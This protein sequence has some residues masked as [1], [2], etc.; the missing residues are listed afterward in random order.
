N[1]RLVLLGDTAQ[2]PPVETSLSPALDKGELAGYASEVWET[3]LTD[4]LRQEENSGILANA[5]KL[6]EML[7]Q[8]E[9]LSGFPIIDIDDYT[10]IRRISGG[11][12]IE[13]INYCYDNYG[14]EETLIITRSNKR[15]NLYNQGIRN[16]VLHKEEELAPGDFLLIVK[17]NYHWIKEHEEISFIAN[18]DIARVIRIKKYHELYGLR[19]ADITCE[20]T[21]YRNVEID[22][23]VILDTIHSEGPCLIHEHQEIVYSAVMEDY[24]DNSVKRKRYEA[25]RSDE[26]YNSLQIKFAYAMT[27]HKAQ[28]SQWKAVFVDLGY[29]TEEHL[30]RDFLRWLYTA[31][32]RATE[33][34]YLVNFP[35]EFFK[36]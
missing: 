32:T 18:G 8:D 1:C 5:T 10:D 24:Q 20:L 9:E 19:F 4:V 15:A 34:L 33:R 6:R 27:C 35:K 36:Y 7:D 30:S 25:L 11:D 3:V 28:G 12:L 26:F 16:T 29:F 17:N 13:E 23:R 2:L 31:F 14:L 22:T 21:D